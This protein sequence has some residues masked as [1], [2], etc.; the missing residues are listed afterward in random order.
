MYKSEEE[1]DQK[2]FQFRFQEAFYKPSSM[3]EGVFT[4]CLIYGN[5]S[6][7]LHNGF[8]FL[9]SCVLYLAVFLLPGIIIISVFGALMNNFLV[10][11]VLGLFTSN[12]LI[13]LLRKKYR[14]SKGITVFLLFRGVFSQISHFLVSVVLAL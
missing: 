3:V 13:A 11:F 1:M 2:R 5:I 12:A 14:T 9:S 7:D 10:S 8:E 6:S 4:P